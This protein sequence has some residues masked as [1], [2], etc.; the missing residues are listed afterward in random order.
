VVKNHDEKFKDMIESVLPSTARKSARDRR[1]R[2]HK[3]SR[4]RQRIALDAIKASYEDTGVDFRDGRRKSELHWMVLDR[5]GADNVGA[6]TRWAAAVV[7][8]DPTL[9][10]APLHVQV[11]HF[12]GILAADVI[13]RHAIQHIEWALKYGA[14][15]PYWSERRAQWVARADERKS[16]MVDA[17][18]RVLAAGRHGDLNRALRRAYAGRSA[19]DPAP[20]EARYFLGWHDIEAFVEATAEVGWVCEIVRRLARSWKPS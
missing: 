9:R 13:G 11:V 16:E 8:A 7:A 19:T 6:L 4:A 17:L 18:H 1:R 10:D 14:E 2:V 15:R 12:A 20:V 3:Q 5:R